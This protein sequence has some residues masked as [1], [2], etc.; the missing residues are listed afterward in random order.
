MK[1][2]PFLAHFDALWESCF[3]SA[4]PLPEDAEPKQEQHPAP[5][6]TATLP[7][8][9]PPLMADASNAGR[10]DFFHPSPD[11]CHEVIADQQDAATISVTPLDAVGRKRLDE[12]QKL[13]SW[14]SADAKSMVS[15]A[16][17]LFSEAYSGHDDE[18]EQALATG[19][20]VLA[21]KTIAYELGCGGTSELVARQHLLPLLPS[22]IPVF[23][24]AKIQERYE[25]GYLNY[26]RKNLEAEKRMS[27][28]PLSDIQPPNIAFAPTLLPNSALQDRRG[29][30]LINAN[31][32][33]PND[34]RV[35][36]PSSHWE[37]VIDETGD[38]FDET[39]LHSS[40]RHLGRFVGVLV[41]IGNNDLPPLNSGWHAV[42][43]ADTSEID[44]V[45]QT[46]LSAR[47]GVLGID[48]QCLPVTPGERWLD[49]IALLIDWTLRLMPVADAPCR[50][51]VK[52]EQRGAF[53]AKQSWDVVRR[54]CLRRLA[55][56]FPHRALRID[57]QIEV[58]GKTGSPFNGFVDS[59]AYTWAE[60]TD[61]SKARLK[62]SGWQGTCLLRSSEGA[63]ARAM[64]HAWDA[65]AQG[66][67]LPAG[68]W[69]GMVCSAD[70]RNPAAFMSSFLT[71]VGNEAKASPTVWSGFLTET[72]ARMAATP[73]DLQRL[74]AAVDWL[75]QY[76]PPHA[77]I[78]PAL[79]LAW[80]TIKLAR[81]NHVGMAEQQWQAELEQLGDQL[82]DE[83]APLV[84]HADLHRAVAATNRFDFNRAQQA[85]ARWQ[86]RSPA[87]P[88]LRYWGQLQSSFGQHAAFLGDNEKAVTFFL[89]A[90][91]TFDRLSDPEARRRDKLQTGCYLA[92]A[93]M[94]NTKVPPE[95]VRTAVELVVG[96]LP[97]A[98][99]R[100]ATSC[101]PTDRYAHHL[102]LRWLT[103]R[104]DAKVQA[105][106]IRKRDSW[107][108]GD[109]HPWPLIQLYRGILLHETDSDTARCL[110]LDA[111][112]R[113][114]S[115]EQGPTVRLIGACCRCVAA[116][117]G[118]PWP[119]AG[120]EL[121]Y[122]EQQ[123]PAAAENTGKLKVAMQ[124][125]SYAPRAMLA[126]ILPF[127]FR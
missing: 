73:V 117:W 54:D 122:L 37:L 75:Q 118:A 48:V 20:Q 6:D 42:D 18:I 27:G 44:R 124:T 10:P 52:I 85:L 36:Q 2:D 33:H 100:L 110:A 17:A 114:F 31:G 13:A 121:E 38:T 12:I 3:P 92:I 56:A 120:Q 9:T 81:T 24:R 96:T 1:D 5:C 49:G 82:L 97:D 29:V 53:E 119:E 86:G 87:E 109:G 11:A 77:S 94:D 64:L 16:I 62:C 67:N 57:L 104:G 51:D 127:N 46:V 43:C 101:E 105:S 47:V 74:A 113:A 70:A 95:E 69:W 23:V 84:C 83:A 111:A 78:L 66:V 61:S 22:T 99:I 30:K 76:Q 34:L 71:L 65:F 126:S 45:V 72:K 26:R 123:L 32:L 102:L 58:V 115:A 91:K 108:T 4:G 7:C 59:I 28:K 79:R 89:E 8:T 35:Q 80:L 93:L 63:D 107:K 25:R 125:S 15:S 88:G 103:H 60:S 50:V 68:L 19:R 39:A 21:L 55:L 106:Y 90:M 41:P 116:D 40:G 112:N 14:D 98:A